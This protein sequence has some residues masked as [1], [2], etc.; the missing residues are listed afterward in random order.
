[1]TH[2]DTHFLY[3]FGPPGAGKSTLVQALAARD[4]AMPTRVNGLHLIDYLGADV[5]EI[6]RDR[7][8]FRGTDALGMTIIDKAEEYVVNSFVEALL[9]EGDRL[10][11]DR[12][13][14]AVYYSGRKLELAYLS[15]PPE[16][17]AARRTKRGSTQDAT[18]VQGRVT[19]AANLW[20]R[21]R[22]HIRGI[23]LDGTR[24]PLEL[25]AQLKEESEVARR[26]A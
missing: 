19:K 2:A 16:V 15:V 6:G 12:F 24:T 21:W 26:F 7:Q 3:I 11:V 8:H 9:A 20:E 25:V 13:L 5:T 10:A 23:E 17:G 22:P 4:V 18:W 14:K 1:M